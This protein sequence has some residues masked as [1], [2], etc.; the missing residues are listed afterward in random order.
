[1]V[2][3]LIIAAAV[4]TLPL[5]VAAQDSTHKMLQCGITKKLYNGVVVEM[6]AAAQIGGYDF[7]QERNMSQ[8][9]LDLITRMRED[10]SCSP[11]MQD[12]VSEV[13]LQVN[14]LRLVE[15][16]DTFEASR[17]AILNMQQEAQRV[18]DAG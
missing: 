15:E 10:L 4:A 14:C 3:A 12:C 2:K 1:M 7:L 17:E 8:T 9:Q 13:A 16:Y 6:R 11:G 18:A 5:A